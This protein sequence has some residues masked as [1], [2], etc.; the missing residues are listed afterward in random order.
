MVRLHGLRWVVAAGAIA[1]AST[2]VPACSCNE[3]RAATAACTGAQNK[4]RCSGCCTSHGASWGALVQ[5]W[6]KCY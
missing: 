2:F 6:C 5:G 3:N 4:Y 1:L